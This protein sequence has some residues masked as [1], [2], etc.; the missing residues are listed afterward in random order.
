VHPKCR[1]K[2]DFVHYFPVKV[3]HSHVLYHLRLETISVH[4]CAVIGG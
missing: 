4:I 1:W 2:K 3:S